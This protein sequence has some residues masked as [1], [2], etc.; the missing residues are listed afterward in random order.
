MYD[1]HSSDPRVRFI[2]VYYKGRTYV[3]FGERTLKEA[4]QFLRLHGL[5]YTC[6]AED[7]DGRVI[8]Q[9]MLDK[10]VFDSGL[11]LKELYVGN[12]YAGLQ[13]ERLQVSF[14]TNPPRPPNLM[15][16]LRAHGIRG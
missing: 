13:M 10:S 12:S 4:I 16:E 14:R 2:K 6:R 5:G 15:D 7:Q 11:G 1:P 8:K 9:R 3:M